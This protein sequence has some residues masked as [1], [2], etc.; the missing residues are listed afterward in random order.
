M[1]RR[2][3]AEGQCIVKNDDP[4]QTFKG[5]VKIM[6]IKLE[7]G[8]TSVSVVSILTISPTYL[9]QQIQCISKTFDSF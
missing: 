4:L 8:F 2:C 9:S 1:Y 6:Q 5:V 7:D 3:G